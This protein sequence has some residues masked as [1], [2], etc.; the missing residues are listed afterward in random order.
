VPCGDRC[1][2]LRS[3]PEACG[4]CEI[5][6][7]AEQVCSLGECAGACGEGLTACDRACV[8]LDS[9]RYHCGACDVACGP[10]QSCDGGTC[11]ALFVACFATDD[12]RT[13]SPDL[14]WTG[15]ARAAGNGPI[16]LALLGGHLF[17]ANSLSHSLSA[18]PVDGGAG[19]EL[20]FPGGSD[21]ENVV[22]HGG[23]LYVSNSGGGTL[24]VVHPATGSVID[25]IGFGVT[26]VNPRG[27]AFWGD[28]AYVALYGLDEDSGG[29][30][31]AV[32]DLGGVEACTAPPCGEVVGTISVLDLAD[33]PGL[34][35][36]SRAVAVA[37][38]VYV[39]LANLKKREGDPAL[40]PLVGYYV[41]PAGN[42]KL[43]VVDAASGEL[44]PPV[45]LGPDC[46]NPGGL[47][48]SGT[49]L[50]VACGDFS[51]QAI[52]PV[53]V[54]GETPVVGDPV[55][56][57]SPTGGFGFVPGAIAFCADMGYV[58]DQWSGDVIRFDP[59][60]PAST[61]SGLSACPLNAPPEEF[62]WAWAADAACAP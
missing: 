55:P 4:S 14:A 60:D 30:E 32:V 18:L 3:D 59:L 21:F 19:R 20:L 52:V 43:A 51:T 39:T 13:V 17:A 9:D 46:L 50:W 44:L 8:A 23:L 7:G 35:F 49:T 34:P 11:R 58:T 48:W 47:A 31:I 57:P 12:V 54:S 22:A 61:Q 38:R 42:G 53:D 27:L 15:P 45:D 40:D 24:L 36:P 56:T 62:G 37:G 41:D 16:S 25:E 10:G 29:Q 26:D 5:A 1:A 28:L 33:E 2:D 6:C